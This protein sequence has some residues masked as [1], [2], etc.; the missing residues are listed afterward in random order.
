MSETHEKP[1]SGHETSDIVAGPIAY[2]GL[3]LGVVILITIFAMWGTFH[4]LAA[5]EAAKSPPANPL[6]AKLGPQLPP[7]PRLQAMPVR[8]LRQLRAAEDAQL[9]TY[10]WVDEKAGVV[11][12]PIERAIEALAERGLP[13]TPKGK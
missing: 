9:S 10:G 1:H 12:I 3:G 8:D 4:L 5:R 11:R 13:K 2:A 7:Q 6:A